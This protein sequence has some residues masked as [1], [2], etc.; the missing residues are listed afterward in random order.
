MP[1]PKVDG[2][3]R[4][5]LTALQRDGRLTN[6]AL[7]E[8]VGLSPTPCLR[9]VRRLEETGV[10]A[11]YGARLDRSRVGLGLTAFVSVSVGWHNDAARQDFEDAVRDCPEVVACYIV[12]GEADF[13]LEVVAPDLDAYSRL[14]I[15]TILKLPGVKDVKSSFAMRVVKAPSSLP[16]DLVDGGAV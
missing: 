9:R 2:F 8:R 5:I 6:V 3:D 15:E 1:K 16:L 13:L 10:I 4:G 12:S 11:G 7:A 14:L